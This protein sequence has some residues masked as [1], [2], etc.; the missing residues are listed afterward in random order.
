MSDVTSLPTAE[1]TREGNMVVS[2]IRFLRE[3]MS[4]QRNP[5]F[6]QSIEG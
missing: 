3:K 2:F 6:A 5:E 1:A 4:V